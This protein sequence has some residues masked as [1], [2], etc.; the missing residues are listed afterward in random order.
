MKSVSHCIK[1]GFTP[2]NREAGLCTCTHANSQLDLSFCFYFA[3]FVM[4]FL[5]FMCVISPSALKD[6][7]VH[8]NGLSHPPN[9][10]GDES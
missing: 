5:S 4:S 6:S 8:Q 3:I 9:L 7:W 1:L 2:Y 10:D